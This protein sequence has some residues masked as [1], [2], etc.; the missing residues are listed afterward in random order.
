M[1]FNKENF[2][3]EGNS[4]EFFFSQTNPL[5]NP[6]NAEKLKVKDC[7]DCDIELVVQI[8]E[9]MGGTEFKFGAP[10]NAYTPEYIKVQVTD[11]NGNFATY[12]EQSSISDFVLDTTALLGSDWTIYVGIKLTG[13]V[14]A[15]CG[16]SKIFT[17]KYEKTE[18][19]INTTTIGAG[20]LALYAK[21][22]IGVPVTSINLGS[23]PVSV[24]PIP[25][26]F[27]AT[28][29]GQTVIT[30]QG[31]NITATVLSVS[32]PTFGNTVMP[33]NLILI[34]GTLDAD[35]TAGSKSGTVEVYTDTESITLTISYTL[36]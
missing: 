22:E 7:G 15:D 19:V 1:A 17:F 25:F 36:V 28:N 30:L 12:T 20:V 31:V 23:F 4:E 10:T 26:E 27:Y 11:G 34:S 29:T 16:C 33:N 32:I 9:T 13:N 14:L 18:L 35:L 2:Y 3:T 6:A 24:T 5:A 8:A 21:D